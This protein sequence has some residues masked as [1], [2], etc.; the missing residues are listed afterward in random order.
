MARTSNREK[1]QVAWDRIESLGGNGVWDGNLVAVSLAGT[2]VTDDDLS[3]F[4][5][6]P[7]VQILDLSDT[8]V[9]DRGMEYLAGLKALELLVIVNTK[10][11]QSAIKSF[12]GEHPSLKIVTKPSTKN[13]INPFTG[14]PF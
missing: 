8:A 11:S 9:G 4:L 3:L 2:G 7:R 1:D 10:I 12:R 13:T 14:K 6:F 5:D